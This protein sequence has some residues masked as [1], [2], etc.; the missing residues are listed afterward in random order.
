MTIHNC[1]LANIPAVDGNYVGSQFMRRFNFILAYGEMIK[2]KS[3]NHLYIKPVQNFDTIKTEPYISKFGFKFEMRNGTIRIL[4]IE[5]GG[6]ADKQGLKLGDEV[7]AIDNGGF[8]IKTGSVKEFIS[9][10]ASKDRLVVE[11]QEK[12]YTLF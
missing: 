11:T 7:V 1:E 10:T 8:D 4:S 12:V 9:Y 6:I 5:L 2:H 3:Q